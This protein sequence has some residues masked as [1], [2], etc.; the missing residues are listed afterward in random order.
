[1]YLLILQPVPTILFSPIFCCPCNIRLFYIWYKSGKK[2]IRNFYINKFVQ[3]NIFQ[4]KSIFSL[5]ISI[6]N[7]Y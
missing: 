1:M 5:Q 4:K 2:S 3:Q 6:Q 7:D